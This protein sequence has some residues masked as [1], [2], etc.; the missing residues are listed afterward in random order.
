MIPFKILQRKKE[1]KT[2]FRKNWLNERFREL[3][4][5]YGNVCNFCGSQD[6]LEFAH[7]LPTK[8]TGMGRGKIRRYYDI[9]KHPLHYILLCHDCH[10]QYDMENSEAQTEDAG[11]DRMTRQN[12][13]NDNDGESTDG[14]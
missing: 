2:A 8:V 9:I 10:K 11:M 3:R 12:D 6:R 7:R 5:N 13:Q 4:F 14:L 1:I